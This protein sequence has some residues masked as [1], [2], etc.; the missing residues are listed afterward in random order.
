MADKMR[1]TSLMGDT[2]GLEGPTRLN[3]QFLQRLAESFSYMD[4]A[5]AERIGRISSLET[6]H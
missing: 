3:V 5:S 1:V 2:D 6:L 4:I